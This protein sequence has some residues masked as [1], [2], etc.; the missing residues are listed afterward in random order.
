[1]K[2]YTCKLCD[3]TFDDFDEQ[4]LWGH[5]QTEHENTFKTVQNLETPQM[6][7]ELYDYFETK[8]FW[9]YINDNGGKVTVDIIA[10]RDIEIYAIALSEKDS[11]IVYFDN[12]IIAR[13]EDELY[14]YFERLGIEIRFCDYCGGIFQAGMTNDSGDLYVHDS[15][16]NDYMDKVYGRG[17][18]MEL[19]NGEEDEL[20]G[21]YIVS[22]DVLGGYKGTGIYYTEYY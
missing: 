22:A 2:K 13:N 8:T 16:F 3:E 18:W 21:Y 12:V 11:F 7:E 10:D 19:G 9:D 20:G 1:M 14:D 6:L 15:C 5:I 4:E 17:K